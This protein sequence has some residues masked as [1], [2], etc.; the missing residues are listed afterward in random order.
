M[1]KHSF[2]GF[3]DPFIYSNAVTTDIADLWRHKP[4]LIGSKIKYS[5]VKATWDKDQ[6]KVN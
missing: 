5:T 3:Y 2:P 6:N 1:S 4:K